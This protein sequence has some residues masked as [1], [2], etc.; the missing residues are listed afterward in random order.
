MKEVDIIDYSSWLPYDGFAEGSGRSEKLWLQS[1]D[2]EIGLFKFPKVDPDTLEVTTEHVS[3]HLA[4]R[5]GTILGIKTA[6]VEIGT[7]DGRVGCM[8]YL[9]NKKYEAIVEGAIFITGKH[10]DY[11]MDLMQETST[12]R[13]YCLD[14]LLEVTDS[15]GVL[16]K[17][18]Q[19]MLFDYLIGNSDRHQNNWAFLVKYAGADRRTLLARVC[20]L[21][22]NGSSLCC[23]VNEKIIQ[24]FLGKD[25][26]RFE[27]LTNTKS[28]SMIRIDGFK[29]KRPTHVEVVEELIKRYPE[30]VEICKLIISKMS[31]EVIDDLIDVYDGILSANKIMLLKKYLKRKIEILKQISDEVSL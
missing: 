3:E 8:S 30:T 19:M 21:Y 5:I 31:D 24:E 28:R 15:P 11:D 13:Y 18:L 1:A 16:K 6:R 17:W 22:D 26:T 9:I 2:G 12:G 7:Y 29:K 27:A 23:Y 25:I 4:H 10:P 14:H 20:P